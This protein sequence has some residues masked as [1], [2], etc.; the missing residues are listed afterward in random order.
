[1]STVA[2]RG[3]AR[4][5]WQIVAWIL[6]ML[7]TTVAAQADC[8]PKGGDEIYNWVTNSALQE[9][10]DLTKADYEL[11]IFNYIL[12]AFDDLHDKIAAHS[13]KLD[14][15]AARIHAKEAQSSE[16]PA[17]AAAIE[18][19]IDSQDLLNDLM[20][21]RAD[22]DEA[23]DRLKSIS[24]TPDKILFL[25][26]GYQNVG[27]ETLV[28][29]LQAMGNTAE[30]SL[31]PR[32]NFH[33]SISFDN[34]GNFQNAEVG[35]QPKGDTWDVLIFLASTA[36]GAATESNE[37]GAFVNIVLENLRLQFD[38]A[39]CL[40]KID[41]QKNKLIQARQILP[42]YLIA[43]NDQLSLFVDTYNKTYQQFAEHA[44]TLQ[45][46][47]DIQSGRWRSLFAYNAARNDAAH[48]VLT[49]ETVQAIQKN[50]GMD[51]VNRRITQ[52]I[53]ISDVQESL[54]GLH[55]Y[56]VGQQT[57]LLTA[58]DNLAGVMTG[59]DQADTL[60]Y[61]QLVYQAFHQ[62]AAF[63]PL[64]DS[65]GSRTKIVIRLIEELKALR[66]QLKSHPCAPA[67]SKPMTAPFQRAVVNSKPHRMILSRNA[68]AFNRHFDDGLCAL[69][70]QDNQLYQCKSEG[71]T[72]YGTRFRTDSGD[73]RKDIL[74]SAND[75]GFAQDNRRVSTAVA[76]ADQNIKQRIAGLKSDFTNVTKALPDYLTTNKK[77]INVYRAKEQTA[78]NDLA[79]DRDA[80]MTRMKPL[81]SSEQQ[82]LNEF[83]ALPSDQNRIRNLIQSVG[84]V[85]MSLPLLPKD[86]LVP[87][88]PIPIGITVSES[89][90]G[91]NGSEIQNA[92]VRERLKAARDLITDQQLFSLSSDALD[93]AGVFAKGSGNA[94]ILA[95]ELIKDSAAV[96]YFRSGELHELQITGI[97]LDGTIQRIGLTSP[98]SV[99]QSL[100]AH[101]NAFQASY[102]AFQSRATN[103]RQ[104]LDGAP[105]QQQNEE[106]INA[107]ERFA[108]E[109]NRAFLSGEFTLGEQYLS[110]AHAVLD[111]LTGH[112]TGVKLS[113]E[114][115]KELDEF[116]KVLN[117]GVAD[118]GADRVTDEIGK[119]FLQIQDLGI[120]ASIFR[121]FGKFGTACARSVTVPSDKNKAECAELGLE[122]AVALNLNAVGM[123]IVAL[124]G[125]TP[126][127]AA[128]YFIGLTMTAA[129]H[130][131]TRAII[132]SPA[133][134]GPKDKQ[135]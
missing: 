9:S 88:A 37:V 82:K 59:E 128:A 2:L 11:R 36:A 93:F 16:L 39:S 124:A 41:E 108:D 106:L 112:D 80:F 110:M 60:Q 95:Q 73:P 62:Q 19:E 81:I 28:A 102:K 78:L 107:G 90:Y 21:V 119:K 126:E 72:P 111:A 101:V 14:G 4:G 44:A 25:L 33:V 122:F 77:A 49:P 26:E 113:S 97:S 12:R 123:L 13:I 135:R 109:A 87:A 30:V 71:G 99:Q 89:I 45:Q 46:L 35:G 103:L 84:G 47:L 34:E 79:V 31:A 20:A 48:A 22:L 3:L 40:A 85:E 52:N 115:Q 91:Q 6:P 23:E 104:G 117:G 129:A 51:D 5:R 116:K 118:A 1:M 114:G 75:G 50:I 10:K 127:G 42:N 17:V 61:A 94:L 98:S 27:R 125:L 53:A 121:D 54:T 96:R 74:Q 15:I 134:T 68:A 24:K 92:V 66:S 57:I 76:E 7:L 100:I 32:Y 133:Y 86:A 65:L 43:P 38:E 8:D 55:E 131:A 69:V 18:R 58:C 83:L 64:Y 120:V 70:T 130:Y 63:A 56:L 29:S 132:A 67:S 105:N